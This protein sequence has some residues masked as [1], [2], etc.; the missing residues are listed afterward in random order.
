MQTPLGSRR[1]RDPERFGTWQMSSWLIR[2]GSVE[3]V[4]VAL[5]CLLLPVESPLPH[6]LKPGWVSFPLHKGLSC[7]WAPGRWA[8]REL[9]PGGRAPAPPGRAAQGLQEGW[10]PQREK[11]P[12]PPSF[13]GDQQTARASAQWVPRV[14][15]AGTV[16]RPHGQ[17]Q[18]LL[19]SRL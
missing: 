19:L 13:Q 17:N 10:L 2:T 9:S 3:W 11:P 4:G 12:P 6:P 14:P 18:L 16:C 7:S 15:S 1:P 5:G 8:G